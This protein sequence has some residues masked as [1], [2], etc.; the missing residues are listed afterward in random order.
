MRKLLVVGAVSVLGLGLMGLAGIR[1]TSLSQD[2]APAEADSVVA[3]RLTVA[4]SA[5]LRGPRQPV[6]FRHDIHAGQDKIQCQ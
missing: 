5:R 2:A 1:G 6:F 4:D 3:V